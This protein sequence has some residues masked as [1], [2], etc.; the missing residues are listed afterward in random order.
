MVEEKGINASRNKLQ[1]TTLLDGIEEHKF[2]CVIGG[3]RRDEERQEQ[4]NDF[5]LTEMTLDNGTLKIKDLN[6]GIY[7]MVKSI[8]E[9][10]LEFSLLVIGQ[11]WTYGNIF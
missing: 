6:Y 2:D 9:N 3:A 11:R 8:L 1:T 7:L 4:K 10:I 5:S